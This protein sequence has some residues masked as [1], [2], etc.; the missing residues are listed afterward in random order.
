MR[1]ANCGI[2]L[3]RK[4]SRRS[5]S[6]RGRGLHLLIEPQ[7]AREGRRRARSLRRLFMHESSDVSPGG[8]E[9]HVWG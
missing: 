5:Q 8:V 1:P 2:C 6:N 9:P 7:G 4:L 3:D